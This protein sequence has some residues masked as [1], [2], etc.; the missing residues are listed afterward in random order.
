MVGLAEREVGESLGLG[1]KT[2]LQVGYA[3]VSK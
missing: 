3:G 1:I 2:G